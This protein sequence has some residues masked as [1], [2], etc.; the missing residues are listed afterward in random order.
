MASLSAKL[1]PDTNRRISEVGADA[2]YTINSLTNFVMATTTRG[3]LPVAELLVTAIPVGK[4]ISALT[5][6]VTRVAS[7][8]LL[9][10][11]RRS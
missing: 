3:T 4:K 7:S 11:S 9:D 5:L 1:S 10:I 2:A 8:I 6:E